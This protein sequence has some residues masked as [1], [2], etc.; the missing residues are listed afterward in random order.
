[1]H[2][3]SVLV[4]KKKNNNNEAKSEDIQESWMPAHTRTCI[5]D[6][7]YDTVVDTM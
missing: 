4:K 5:L 6:S 7:I 2:L 1:M 3:I